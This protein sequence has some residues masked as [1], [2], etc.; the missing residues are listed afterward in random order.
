MRNAQD[1]LDSPW[2]TYQSKVKSFFSF[3][4]KRETG[5]EEG[6]GRHA[7]EAN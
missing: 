1:Y 7:R 3:F 2:P 4:L 6:S 5:S